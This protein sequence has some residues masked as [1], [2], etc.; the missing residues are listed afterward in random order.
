MCLLFESIKI[1]NRLV[2]NIEWH[3]QRIKDSLEHV[4]G[5]SIPFVPPGEKNNNG[6]SPF[7]IAEILSDM[8]LPDGIHKCRMTYTLGII[9]IQITPYVFPHSQTY[10]LVECN[11]LNYDHKYADRLDI[12][13]LFGKRQDADDIIIVK[14]G[15]ITDSSTANLVFYDGERYV[16]PDTPLLEG[17]HRARLLHHGNIV[18]ERITPADLVKFQSFCTINAMSKEGFDAMKPISQIVL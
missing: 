18:S 17:T 13:E 8:E 12:E 5:C 2:C 7:F 14:N 11:G 15:C 16:T 6:T 9:D 3:L 10:R 4:F 1:E